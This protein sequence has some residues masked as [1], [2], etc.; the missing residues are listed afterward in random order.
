VTLVNRTPDVEVAVL[1][2]GRRVASVPAGGEVAVR[3]SPQRSLLATLPET[4]FFARYRETFT[5]HP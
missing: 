1:V 3:L 2:D 4:S 5:S